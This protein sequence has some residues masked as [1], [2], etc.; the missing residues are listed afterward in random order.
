MSACCGPPMTSPK[1]SGDKSPHSKSRGAIQGVSDGIQVPP[2][3]KSLTFFCS[4]IREQGLT[5]AKLWQRTV[6]HR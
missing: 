2:R 1:E 4:L 3:M 5:P 6:V